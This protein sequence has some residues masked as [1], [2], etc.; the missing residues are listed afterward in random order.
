MLS[1]QLGYSE[2]M[3]EKLQRMVQFTAL[4]Y[5]PAWLSAP[6]PAEAPKNDLALYQSLLRYRNIDKPVAKAALSKM[7][8]HM[9]YLKPQLATLSLASSV[10]K[11]EEKAAI[12]SAM[13]A[14]PVLYDADKGAIDEVTPFIDED[15][16]LADLVD[17]GSWLIFD[18]MKMDAK[19]WLERPV[20]EWE[21][22]RDYVRY[23]DFVRAAKVTNDVAER[24]IGLIQ[25]FA[26]TVT[27]DEDQ[28]Q[29][30]LQLVEAHRRKVSSFG[31]GACG[32]M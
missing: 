3:V 16:M 22:H 11:D 21:A 6:L 17:D 28:L 10:V 30:L 25:D 2:E 14:N 5:V 20:S 31:K 27:K 23:C 19:Q 18:L 4:F 8:R 29:W 24:A 1:S 13:L 32:E 15:T 12:A 9:G 26:N 7:G